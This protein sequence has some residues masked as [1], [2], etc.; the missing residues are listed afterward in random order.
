VKAQEHVLKRFGRS[1]E[2]SHLPLGSFVS[3][4]PAGDVGCELGQRR[5]AT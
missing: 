3:M 1:D 4:E 5:V 2:A